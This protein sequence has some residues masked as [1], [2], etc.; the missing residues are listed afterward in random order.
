MIERKKLDKF[1][2]ISVLLKPD[3]VTWPGDPVFHREAAASILDGDSCNVSQ[4]SMGSHS[5]THIDAPSHYFEGA[6]SIDQLLLET[7]VGEALVVDLTRSGESTGEAGG[8]SAGRRAGEPNYAENNSGNANICAKSIIVESSDM[9]IAASDL[10]QIDLN[11]ITRLLL[12]TPNS[13]LYARNC[14]T[15]R[16]AYLT[17]DAAKYLVESGIGLVGIDYLSIDPP[18]CS[19]AHLI[20]LEAGVVI[21]ETIDLSGVESGRYELL[22]LPLKIEGSDGAPARAL[23]RRLA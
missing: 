18:E 9:K 8:E 17:P 21:L 11:G 20:L 14:F 10:E 16:Y 7:L 23:L 1:I 3:S 22:C 12:K 2:D 4:I 19:D 6:A 5:G 13:S 15:E